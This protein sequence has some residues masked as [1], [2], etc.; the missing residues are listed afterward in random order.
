MR[1]IELLLYRLIAR[2]TRLD[3][4]YWSNVQKWSFFNLFWIIR[5]LNYI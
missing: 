4:Y 1:L 3:V 5:P 2:S